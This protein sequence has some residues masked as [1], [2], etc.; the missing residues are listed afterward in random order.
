MHRQTPSQVEAGLEHLHIEEAVLRLRMPEPI[1]DLR[2]QAAD[3]AR[4]GRQTR[5]LARP[6]VLG[7]GWNA[8]A[9][10]AAANHV[11]HFERVKGGCHLGQSRIC[12]HG[13]VQS[14]PEIVGVR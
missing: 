14:S 6:V 8:V 1:H 5:P 4:L 10:V 12:I 13:G 2:V 11:R 3:V 9:V 7:W